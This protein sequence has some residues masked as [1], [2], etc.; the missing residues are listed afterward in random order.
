MY[1]DTEAIAAYQVAERILFG[2]RTMLEGE[3]DFFPALR[4]KS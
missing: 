3:Q 2:K 1:P 4:S